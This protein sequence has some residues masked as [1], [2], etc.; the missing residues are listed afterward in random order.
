MKGEGG[1]RQLQRLT[2]LARGQFAAVVAVN[3]DHGAG[4]GP[5]HPARVCQPLVRVDERRHAVRQPQGSEVCDDELVLEAVLAKQPLVLRL[6]PEQVEVDPV[7]D[8][9]DPA[10]IDVLLIDHAVLDRVRVD[11]KSI[12]QAI[13]ETNQGLLRGSPEVAHVAPA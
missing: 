8:R 3:A 1:R 5:A 10:G 13:G 2:D 11:E 4:Q 6:G 12:D 7:V 9:R